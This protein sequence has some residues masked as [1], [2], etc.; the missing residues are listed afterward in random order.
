LKLDSDFL[1]GLDRL[2]ISQQQWED[3]AQQWPEHDPC[4]TGGHPN[5]NGKKKGD[6]K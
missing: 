4:S 1:T 5:F 3:S 2:C 6:S